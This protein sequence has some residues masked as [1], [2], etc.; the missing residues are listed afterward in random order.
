MKIKRLFTVLPFFVL[1]A[2]TFSSCVST[3]KGFQSSPV[4]S[5]NVELDPIKADIQVNTKK[6]LKGTSEST[7]FLIFRISG[8]NTVADGINYSSDAGASILEL[9]N[10]MRTLRLARL[11]KVRGAAAYK[12]LEGKDYDVL[13]H[14]N[15]SITTRNYLI[16]QQYEVEVTGYGAKYKNFRTEKQ[17][18]IITD[19]H[20]EYIF[21]EK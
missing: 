12:A 13:V 2:A 5:R 8:D 14:P 15:Y 17:K 16:I 3:N 7:Y 1:I 9:L 6:K 19:N 10:P 11:D 20:K 4:I 21:P 18:V